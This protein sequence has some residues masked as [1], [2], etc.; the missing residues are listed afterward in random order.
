MWST[1]ISMIYLYLNMPKQRSNSYKLPRPGNNIHL[2]DDGYDTSKSK[3]ARHRALSRSS[4]KHGSLVVM[5]R[6]NLIKNLSRENKNKY[7][8][9]D[10]VEYLK[11]LYAQEKKNKIGSK[12]NSKKGS[13]GNKKK[14]TKR[15]NK[16]ELCNFNWFVILEYLTFYSLYINKYIMNCKII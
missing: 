9:K 8:M 14:G 11:K 16:W 7:I 15:G 2:S 5:K 10:D 1:L 3:L 13:R 4:K 6:L 12:N